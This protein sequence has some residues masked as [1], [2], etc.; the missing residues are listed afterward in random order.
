MYIGYWLARYAKVLRHQKLL[1][2]ILFLVV[3]SVIRVIRVIFSCKGR[4][5]NGL[6]VLDARRWRKLVNWF[7]RPFVRTPL[8]TNRNY[9]RFC[10]FK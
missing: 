1:G 3:Y 9:R 8:K 6:L 7:V 4:G 5:R 10:S 2:P